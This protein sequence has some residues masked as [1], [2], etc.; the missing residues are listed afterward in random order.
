MFV[1]NEYALELHA[2]L[3]NVS[4]AHEDCIIRYDRPDAVATHECDGV[5]APTPICYRSTWSITGERAAGPA[6]YASNSSPG[7]RPNRNCCSH[8]SQSIDNVKTIHIVTVESRSQG[9]QYLRAWLPRQ[10]HT[11]TFL[12]ERSNVGPR[13]FFTMPFGRCDLVHALI[14]SEALRAVS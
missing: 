1:R 5:T 4:A 9:E 13:Y 3:R 6:W 12:T 7:E 2:C 10:H 11:R 8:C 14:V